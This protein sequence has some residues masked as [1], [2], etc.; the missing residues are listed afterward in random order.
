MYLGRVLGLAVVRTDVLL[1]S[2]P[3]PMQQSS[4]SGNETSCKLE[5]AHYPKSPFGFHIDRLTQT[6]KYIQ[7]TYKYLSTSSP[8]VI[9]TFPAVWDVSVIAHR[10]AGLSGHYHV[11][12]PPTQ[13]VNILTSLC[14]SVFLVINL[15][16]RLL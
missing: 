3:D 10:F 8:V 15:V 13:F 6:R 9:A 12:A 2:F 16:S 11:T 5:P 4:W 7:K 14:L 1:V